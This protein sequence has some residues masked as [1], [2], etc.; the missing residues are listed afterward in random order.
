MHDSLLRFVIWDIK[1]WSWK[2]DGAFYRED[3]TLRLE[4]EDDDKKEHSVAELNVHPL[5]HTSDDAKALLKRRGETFWSCRS[6]RFV[7]LKE[8]RGCGWHA[9]SDERYMIDLKTY[10]ELHEDHKNSPLRFRRDKSTA[11]ELTAEVFEQE[12]PPADN[13]VYLLPLII[14][15]FHL[16]RKNWVDLQVDQVAEV[17]WNKEAVKSLVLDR[18]TKDLIQALISNQL[19]AEKSTDLISGKGNGMDSPSSWWPRNRKDSNR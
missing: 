5:Q 8:N 18:K 12:E 7:S 2:F 1:A 13:F 10:Q 6:S 4:I 16:R 17:T 3:T 19:D 14:K 11:H 15:G 9:S